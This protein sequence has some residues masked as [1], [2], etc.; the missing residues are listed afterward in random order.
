M[1]GDGAGA[2]VSKLLAVRGVAAQSDD[3]DA[4][5][6][7]YTAHAATQTR[8]FDGVPETM[9]ALA[10]EGWTLAVC[11]NKP[12]RPA[13]KLLEALGLLELLAAVGVATVSARASRIRRM[14]S[15]RSRRPG[16]RRAKP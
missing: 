6:A 3:L 1:V 8:P 9:R 2:L 12:E 7:D 10:A 13:R 5:L 11:T 14:C 15:P 4:F 16:A